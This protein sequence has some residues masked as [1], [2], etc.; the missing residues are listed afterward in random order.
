MDL[1]KVQVT[2]NCV[3]D[4]FREISTGNCYYYV[5]KEME[6]GKENSIEDS[7]LSEIIRL[8]PKALKNNSHNRIR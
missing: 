2:L 7:M 3:F 1:T 5:Y 4:K 6:T 8:S